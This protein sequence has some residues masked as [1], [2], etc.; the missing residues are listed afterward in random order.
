MHP[1]K[2]DKKRMFIVIV[3][4]NWL[5][6]KRLLQSKFPFFSFHTT[7]ISSAPSTSH[8]PLRSCATRTQTA[9]TSQYRRCDVNNEQCDAVTLLLLLLS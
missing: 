5:L 1:L 9:E 3:N 4:P 7:Q 2:I 6:M 8:A